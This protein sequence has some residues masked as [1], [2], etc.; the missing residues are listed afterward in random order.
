MW[1][2]VLIGWKYVASLIEFEGGLRPMSSLSLGFGLL[3]LVDL[4]GAL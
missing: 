2:G 3:M 1:E 4:V